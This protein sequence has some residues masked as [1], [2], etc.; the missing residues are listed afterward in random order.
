MLACFCF[1][2]FCWHV[3][4]VYDLNC[5]MAWGIM[6]PFLIWVWC[7]VVLRCRQLARERFAKLRSDVLVKLELL[8]QKHGESLCI[9]IS[10]FVLCNFGT[11]LG[12]D[13]G[14]FLPFIYPV[15]TR[16]A[17]PIS[18]KNSWPKHHQNGNTITHGCTKILKNYSPFLVPLPNKNTKK[19]LNP[20]FTNWRPYLN[21][22]L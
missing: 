18:S 16:L 10:L 17:V 15:F 3:L 21:H 2:Y 7:R 9:R 12:K 11:T 13:W 22:W 8:D 1:F 20:E 19:S 5:S 6:Q 4:Q 14:H